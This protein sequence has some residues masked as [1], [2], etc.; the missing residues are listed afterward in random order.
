MRVRLRH[1]ELLDLIAKSNRTQNHWAIKIGISRGHWSQIVNGKHPYL[2]AKTRER[3]LEAFAVAFDQLFEIEDHPSTPD[4]DF[5]TAIADRYT[6]ERE[7]GEGGMGT[8]YLARD[9]KH[10]RS[11]ALK[12]ISSEVLSGVGVDQFLKEIRFASRLQHHHILPLYDSGRAAGQPYF[13]T[14]YLESGS[15][16]DELNRRG[17]LSLKDTVRLCQ[18][19][20][21]ALHEAHGHQVLHCDVKPGNVL[22]SGTHP[23]VSDFGIS[24][25]VH[26]EFLAWGRKAELNSS[27]GTPAYVSPEQASGEHVLDA[28]SD[29][30][31]LACMVFEMLA[32]V[33][34]Y[35]G[36]T[37]MEVVA[38]RFVED[39]PDIRDVVPSVPARVAAV[40]G[41]S[42]SVNP[43]DRPATPLE[44]AKQLDAASTVRQSVV[45]DRGRVAIA[46]LRK[47]LTRLVP[48]GKLLASRPV[49]ALRQDLRSTWQSLK[50]R[51]SFSLII[52]ATLAIGIGM[53]TAIFSVLHGAL[54]KPLPYAN[55]GELVRIG[56]A[57]PQFPGG[58]LEL[59]AGN[60]TD[61]RLEAQ[62]FTHVA[63]FVR[64]SFNVT[65]PGAPERVPG[66]QVSGNFFSMLGA[67]AQLGRLLADRD[68]QPSAAPVVVITDAYW[69]T[70][71]LGDSTVIGSTI[72]VNG[73]QHTIVGVLPPG[74]RFLNWN[75]Q[76][77]AL[78]RF[79]EEDLSRRGSNFLSIYGRLR[80]ETPVSLGS[81]ELASIGQRL[82]EEGVGGLA[83]ATL[84]A[85]N[86]QDFLTR[87]TRSSLYLLAGAVLLVLLV[88]CA[89]VANLLLVR[90]EARTRELA[91]RSALG[92]GRRRLV[93][94]LITES[95]FIALIGGIVGVVIAYVGLQVLLAVFGSNVPSAERIE[96]NWTVLR[97][98]LVASLLTGLLVSLVPAFRSRANPGA[99]RDGVM[100]A[101]RGNTLVRKGL[102]I[103]EV[104]LT[105]VLMTSTGL[106]LRSFWNAQG[107][108]LGLVVDDILTFRV[109]P[110]QARYPDSESSTRFIEDFTERI[111][112]IPGVENV[113]LA[114]IFPLSG[115]RFNF[116][117]S[118]I[119]DPE[120]TADFI[121]FRVINPGYFQTL[122]IPIVEGRNFTLADESGTPAVAIIN[123]RLAE[124][125]LGDEPALGVRLQTGRGEVEVIG[126]ARNVRE[127]GPDL[128]EPPI[129]YYPARQLGVRGVAFA[130][131]TSAP[132]GQTIEAVRNELQ[133]I[134]AE[135]PLYGTSLMSTLVS[136]RLGNRRFQLALI[137]SF[138][139]VALLL[140]AIGIYGVMSYT[141]Q[142][143]T[144]EL[145][146]RMALGATG[147]KIVKMVAQEAG[148]LVVLGG[149]L[150]LAGAFAMRH[151]I[152]R[153][154][155][156]VDTADP[157]T[158]GTVLLVLGFTAWAACYVPAKRAASVA[159]AEALRQE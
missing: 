50:R 126:V 112:S 81:Q 73:V 76:I 6:I 102:V 96:I 46:N 66:A 38:K 2:S 95:V 136:E 157:F 58:L 100:Q 4:L 101:S 138:A 25:A 71:V 26:A 65:G 86:L 131:R 91:V 152:A 99:L 145:G 33:P 11:V 23:Y 54:F 108:D 13:V 64:Q 53:N 94:Q 22:L 142:Q 140:G 10:E 158:Y 75:P 117:V 5:Q 62:S 122:G 29:V 156:E 155:F 143:R 9:L 150:G 146:I 42:M 154:L 19:I 107:Q 134:D 31:S 141:V 98:A 14:P 63:S 28:R 87:R 137:T 51:P 43:Q 84:S 148:T 27:A 104:A 116:T 37:T 128:A 110:P 149:A 97:F 18:G 16:R 12:V 119:S 115:G 77:Y 17:A 47:R 130:V 120:Q 88:A 67:S 41:E 20:A 60:F 83:N 129:I 114:S 90:S 35:R 105:L 151:L 111:R 133:V 118:Q 48:L 82:Q 159:A 125:I 34:P 132:F 123:R 1:A 44:F 45:R 24:R 15:L 55:P 39:P 69:R 93:S 139:I 92:A 30:Y 124:L 127:F 56:R 121:E 153:W 52:I 147:E 57:V 70:R 106:L 79:D 61:V 40:L 89:N 36:D 32:G 113:G 103:G 144:R 21:E 80:P 49:T 59:S 135:L 85:T 74:F 8:V 109:L 3:I 68:D 78:N 7:V 72:G